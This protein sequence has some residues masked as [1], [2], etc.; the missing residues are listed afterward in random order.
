MT[1]TPITPGEAIA[2]ATKSGFRPTK[3]V[4]RGVAAAVN[5]RPGMRP[6]PEAFKSLFTGLIDA[7]NLVL[8]NRNMQSVGYVDEP[9]N[10]VRLL[11]TR[12]FPLSKGGTDLQAYYGVLTLNPST[13]L[14]EL[15]GATPFNRQPVVGDT[16]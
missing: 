5:N 12:P 2:L 9:A 1:I 15:K 16:K 3:V 8:M 11:G 14:V 6:T 4:V 7:R 10:A 13:S